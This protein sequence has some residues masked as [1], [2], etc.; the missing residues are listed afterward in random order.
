MDQLEKLLEEI[1]Q[2]ALVADFERMTSLLPQVEQALGE[3]P[4]PKNGQVLSRLK[5]QAET[6]L[7]LLDAARRGIHA[8]RRRVEEVIRTRQVLQTYDSRG[9][10]ADI[11]PP[12]PTAGRF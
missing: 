9:Q 3:A 1:R 8:A 7:R 12:G 11:V 10:R 2:A 4:P 6:N 5:A